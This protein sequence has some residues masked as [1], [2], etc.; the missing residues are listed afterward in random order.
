VAG[1]VAAAPPGRDPEPASL[2]PR[3]IDPSD[4]DD[5]LRLQAYIWADQADRRRRLET[6]LDLAAAS[7]LRVERADAADW[8]EARFGE[9][10]P[11]VASV[12]YHSIVWQYL[13]AAARGR[14]EVA[15]ARAGEH[16]TADAP[17]VWLRMEPAPD[18]RHAELC[19]TLWPAGHERLLADADFHGRW[20]R[21]LPEPIDAGGARSTALGSR[22]R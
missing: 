11:G 7:N 5:R 19:L 4:P 14:I 13:P 20:V 21:W 2:R 1:S 15:I 12:L 9:P 3:P 18:A 8:V 6:A 17:F 16:A 22:P 10:A